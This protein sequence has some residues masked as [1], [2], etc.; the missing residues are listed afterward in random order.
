MAAAVSYVVFRVALGGVCLLAGIEKA[1]APRAFFDGIIMYRLI[2]RR[3]APIV[4]ASLIA[5]ELGIGLLLVTGLL[6]VVAA[7][8]AIAL[9]AVFSAALAVSLARSNRAPCHCFGASDDEKI[10]PVA[11]I[12]VACAAGSRGLRARLRALRHRRDCE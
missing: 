6:P 3:L 8:G 4:G 1:R 10:S 2:P 11:L 5:A 9:F 7:V 12:R